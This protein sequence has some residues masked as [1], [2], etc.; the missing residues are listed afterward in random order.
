VTV[1]CDHVTVAHQIKPYLFHSIAVF[2]VKILS[3][4][5]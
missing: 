1:S 3:S 2:H 5:I 4:Y